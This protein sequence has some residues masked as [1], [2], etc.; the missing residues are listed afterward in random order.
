MCMFVRTLARDSALPPATDIPPLPLFYQ[1]SF[2]DSS[3]HPY[4][5]LPC[6]VLYRLQ[7]NCWYCY[8]YSYNNTRATTSTPQINTYVTTSA[9]TTILASAA[10]PVTCTI[11]TT[12]QLLVKP[13]L[14]QQ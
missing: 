1:L 11:T 8:Y 12:S 5:I 6:H 7:E 2:P 14:K 10:A 4:F 9:T 13:L 3:V